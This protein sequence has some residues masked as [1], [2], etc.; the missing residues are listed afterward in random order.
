MDN[1][2]QAVATQIVIW[3]NFLLYSALVL[4]SAALFVLFGYLGVSISIFLLAISIASSILGN[5]TFYILRRKVGESAARLWMLSATFLSPF[6]AIFAIYCCNSSSAIS[7][8]GDIWIWSVIIAA[9]LA[10]H[11]VSIFAA[12]R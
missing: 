3:L 10:P 5:V 9:F 7:S 6:C 12:K 11:V 4:G 8:S 2:K 1:R